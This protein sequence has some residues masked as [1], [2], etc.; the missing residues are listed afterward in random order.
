MLNY[1]TPKASPPVAVPALAQTLKILA[2]PKRLAI[3]DLLMQGL[4]CNCELADALGMP[5]NLISHHLRVLREAGLVEME[6]DDQDARWIYYT[7]NRERVAELNHILGAFFD[8]E[9][10]QERT[11]QC[12]PRAVPIDQETP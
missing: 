1:M 3:F 7:V 5:A 11:P 12:G 2:D 6:R 4:Q 10:I 9:R 8:L